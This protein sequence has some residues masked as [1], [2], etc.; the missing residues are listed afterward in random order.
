MELVFLIRE[1]ESTTEAVTWAGSTRAQPCPPRG[2]SAVSPDLDWRACRARL[3][4]CCFLWFGR[5]GPSGIKKTGVSSA[6]W[7]P[8]KGLPAPGVPPAPREPVTGGRHAGWAVGVQRLPLP[9]SWHPS[10]LFSSLLHLCFSQTSPCVVATGTFLELEKRSSE[11]YSE[12]LPLAFPPPPPR[13]GQ[14][15]PRSC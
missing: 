9:D 3:V 4:Y 7:R 6:W 15:L 10:V 1:D 13:R 11:I 5:S 2:M 12:C 14:G 8:S